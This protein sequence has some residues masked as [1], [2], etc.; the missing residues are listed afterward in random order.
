MYFSDILFAACADRFDL[1]NRK[2]HNNIHDKNE[3]GHHRHVL[4]VVLVKLADHQRDRL[5][6]AVCKEGNCGNGHHTVDKEI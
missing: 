4:V 3:N 6:G 5:I 2:L 1:L